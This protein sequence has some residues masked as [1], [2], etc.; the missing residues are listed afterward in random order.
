MAEE[1][2]QRRLAAIRVADMVGYSQLMREDEAGTLAP[3]GCVETL[4]IV[5]V[6]RSCSS[7]EF[8]PTSMSSLH[9]T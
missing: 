1:R 6:R 2:V 7:G 3:L 4:G 9:V 8:V 5:G